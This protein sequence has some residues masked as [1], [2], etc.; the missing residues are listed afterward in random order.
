MT[1]ESQIKAA[2]EKIGQFQRV[3]EQDINS[4]KNFFSKNSNSSADSVNFPHVKLPNEKNLIIESNSLLITSDKNNKTPSENF[5]LLPNFLM[6]LDTLE[7]Y[8]KAIFYLLFDN[9][10]SLYDNFLTL[11]LKKRKSPDYQENIVDSYC[12]YINQQ[13]LFP[14]IKAISTLLGDASPENLNNLEPQILFWIEFTKNLNKHFTESSKTEH[15]VFKE[16][17][18]QTKNPNSP[19]PILDH[20]HI[21][22]LTIIER[23]KKI[24]SLQLQNQINYSEAL[25]K[26]DINKKNNF[27]ENF[28]SALPILPKPLLKK[29]INSYEAL[30]R[31]NLYS[32][33]P[34]SPYSNEK[35]TNFYG[36]L[37][38]SLK[39]RFSPPQIQSNQKLEET[40]S[41]PL[42]LN[43]FSDCAAVLSYR[44]K[45]NFTKIKESF[46]ASLKKE[47]N[48]EDLTLINQLDPTNLET[49]I[50]NIINLLGSQEI[51]NG[52]T[53]N[54]KTAADLLD[55]LLQQ[56]QQQEEKKNTY[57]QLTIFLFFLYHCKCILENK[58]R[59]ENIDSLFTTKHP[60]WNIQ[61]NDSN[62]VN[63]TRTNSISDGSDGSTSVSNFSFETISYEESNT[64]ENNSKKKFFSYSTLINIWQ[65]LLA[66][67]TK[68]LKSIWEV[69][70]LGTA[71]YINPVNPI[72]IPM[73]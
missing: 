4:S 11:W 38:K 59:N 1:I 22:Y 14:T 60:Q 27:L 49:T 63:S 51:F 32:F 13:V 50:D 5:I 65:T 57:T 48:D 73:L 24:L 66:G 10:L 69:I 29:L 7:K 12:Q 31:K 71:S 15:K 41:N 61:N 30:L 36:L 55:Y 40:L 17:L 44:K 9:V 47:N 16:K 54:L 62:K 19:T 45:N 18:K 70:K 25:L 58:K 21:A 64:S 67:L 56:Q 28:I 37:L 34:V 68:L 8:D 26:L 72:P 43:I 2:L 23:T 39:T 20:R 52:K 46:I 33:I 6:C 35:I 3:Y 42:V 53:T